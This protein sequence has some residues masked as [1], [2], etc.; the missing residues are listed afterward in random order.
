VCVTDA[1]RVH[2]HVESIVKHQLFDGVIVITSTF[3][4][5]VWVKN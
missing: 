4:G 5:V 3:Y 2:L 1:D